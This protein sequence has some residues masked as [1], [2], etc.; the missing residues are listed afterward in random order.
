MDEL[1]GL[2]IAGGKGD[3]EAL[4]RLLTAVYDE[5]RSLAAAYL[6]AERPSHTLQP[7]ALVH[8]AYMRLI[9]QRSVDWKNR[10]Q[11]F[12]LAA[13]MMRRILVNHAEAKA[14]EKRGGGADRVTLNDAMNVSERQEVDVIAVDQALSRLAE[15]DERQ[16]Q[17][18]ELRFFAGLTVEEIAEI[19]GVS[20]PTVKRDWSMAKAW[21]KRELAA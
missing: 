16:A 5:L 2:L 11:F 14:A 7:T 19:L 18:V 12:G 8:E 1:T 20:S 6:R 13:Q 17:I 21:L 15:L 4:D 3:R 9:D 10:A